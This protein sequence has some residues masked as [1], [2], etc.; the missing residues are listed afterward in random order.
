MSTSTQ[1]RLV[2]LQFVSVS[3]DKLLEETANHPYEGPTTV[4]HA[5]HLPAITVSAYIARIFRYAPCSAECFITALV[6]IRRILE[7][8]GMNFLQGATV[9]RLIISAV[10]LSSKYLDD[11]YYNNS[12]YAKIGGISPKEMNALEVEMLTF[13][14]YDLSVSPVEYE[15]L[16]SLLFSQETD[17]NETLSNVWFP[18]SKPDEEP[19]AG[20]PDASFV[21][22]ARAACC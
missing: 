3:I 21:P 2:L 1:P 13:L 20:S 12:F 14:N 19:F 15:R 7:S 5:R 6:Y 22:T 8:K 17:D 11:I 4:F 18:K 10:L 16:S 9:H